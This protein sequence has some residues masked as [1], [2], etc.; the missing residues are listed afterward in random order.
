MYSIRSRGSH[1]HY[2]CRKEPPGMVPPV[3]PLPETWREIGATHEGTGA[4][5]GCHGV[6]ASGETLWTHVENDHRGSISS[7]WL[8]MSA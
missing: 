6:L 3:V 1:I 7:A 5:A 8:H 4:S 2:S